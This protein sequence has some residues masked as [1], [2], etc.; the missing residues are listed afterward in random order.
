MLIRW[1]T[2]LIRWRALRILI[3]ARLILLVGRRPLL[4]ALALRTL[5]VARIVGSLVAVGA[6][7]HL[8]ALLLHLRA[9]LAHLRAELIALVVVQ[10]AH[11]LVAECAA[12]AGIA[13]ASFGVRARVLVDERLNALLL[14]AGEVEVAESLRPVALEAPLAGRGGVAVR[15]PRWR[16]ILLLSGGGEGQAERGQERAGGQKVSLHG[17]D[18]IGNAR[19]ARERSIRT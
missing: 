17:L 13:R 7:L 4:I 15:A 1:R 14:V 3:V 18:T 19:N 8:A 16:L 2:L 11:D 10:D 6:A 12:G 9:T 5:A